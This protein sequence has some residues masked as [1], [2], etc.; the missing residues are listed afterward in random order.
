MRLEEFLVA[1]ENCTRL[2]E[3][4][5]VLQK[6]IESYHLASF[7]FVD[8]S[9]SASRAPFFIGTHEAGFIEV[10]QNDEA[11]RDGVVLAAA[12][13]GESGGRSLARRS[14]PTKE[15]EIAEGFTIPFRY[16]NHLGHRH[17]GVCA[18]T[19][20]S[21]TSATRL[22]ID[23]IKLEL[24]MIILH[25]AQKLHELDAARN[26]PHSPHLNLPVS[27][28]NGLRLT[29][30]EKDVLVWAGRG[31]TVQETAAIL[32]ISYNTVETHIR[33]AIGKLEAAT[34]THA[35]VKGVY[36]RLLDI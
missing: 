8:T 9:R 25:W 32:E 1:I 30:R 18:F 27:Q 28:T 26:R 7:G 35:V 36:L 5:T 11:A 4:K 17:S 24:R 14:D 3:L 12:R 34:K 20:K 13:G 15:F 2:E 16:N 33:H 23:V 22:P 21:G 19:W 10:M 31:K 6:T 29:E